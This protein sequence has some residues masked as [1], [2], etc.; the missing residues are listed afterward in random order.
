MI[1][2][3]GDEDEMTI[4]RIREQTACP[5][6]QAMRIQNKNDIRKTA[7][8]YHLFDTYDPGQYGGSGQ[9]FNWD[10]I[11]DFQGSFFLAGGLNIDNVKIAIAKVNPYCVDISSGVESDGKKDRNKIVNIIQKIRRMSND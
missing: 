3:H 10:L 6:I 7:A 8:D 5:I 2:L 9:A 4:R 1:Q 11:N